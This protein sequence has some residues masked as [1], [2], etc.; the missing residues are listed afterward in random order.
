VENGK[1]K[2][3]FSGLRIKITENI[4]KKSDPLKGA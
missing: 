1:Q 2:K 3:I 4:E